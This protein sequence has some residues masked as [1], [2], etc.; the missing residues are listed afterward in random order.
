MMRSILLTVGLLLLPVLVSAYEM[1]THEAITQSA[2]NRSG[3]DQVLRGN[4]GQIDGL[5]QSVGG[6][7]LIEWLTQGARRED[8]V[9][10]FFNHFHNPL[11]TDWSQAGLLGSLGQSSVL[12]G[13]NRSQSFPSWSWQDVRQAYF[14]AL[15]RPPRSDRDTSL[16]RTFEGLGRQIHLVQDAASPA[17]ARNDPHLFYNYESLVDEVRTEDQSTFDGWLAG[18]PDTPGAPDPG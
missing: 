18:S 6:Q 4:L 1:P 11:A 13:Q 5:T 3:A 2:G 16:A 17:H 7:R 15:T 14:E 10:R 9:P 12:W 8:N